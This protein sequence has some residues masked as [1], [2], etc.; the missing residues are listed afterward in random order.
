MTT[1]PPSAS[2]SPIWKRRCWK[3]YAREEYMHRSDSDF[4]VCT[5][6]C[7][8]LPAPDTP[9]DASRRK[10]YEVIDDKWLDE[11]AIRLFPRRPL[12]TLKEGHNVLAVLTVIPLSRST[13]LSSM[14]SEVNELP[15]HI[16][17][18]QI[19]AAAQKRQSPSTGA[20]LAQRLQTQNPRRIDA[21]YDGRPLSLMGPSITIYHTVFANFLKRMQESRHFTSDGLD[22]A[23]NFVTQAAA[24]HGDGSKR[25][26]ELA[27]WTN[28]GVHAHFLR[29]TPISNSVGKFTPDGAVFASRETHDGFRALIS[30]A[31]LETE[32]GEG[33]G[34]PNA[35]A[36]NVYVAYYPS[37][38]AQSVRDRSCCPALLIGLAGPTI[39]VSGAVFA[40]QLVV[41]NLGDPVCVVPRLNTTGRSMLDDAGHRVAQ[42]FY[43]LRECLKEL[44]DYYAALIQ[45]ITVPKRHLRSVGV[46][47]GRPAPTST[48]R[49]G[50]SPPPPMIS[51]HFAQYKD[52]EGKSVTLTYT[53]RL[54]RDYPVKAVFVAEAKTDTETRTVV[55]KFTPAYCKDAHELLARAS[56]PQAPKL[57]FCEFV[58][59]VGMWVVVMDYV[60]GKEVTNVLQDPVHI[61]SLEG[62]I[63][64]LHAD[65]FVFGDLREP[66]VL[67][68]DDK[69][70]LIDFDWCG[71]QG[72]ARYPSDIL[73]EE[74]AW[75]SGVQRGG[76]LEKVHD[77][78]HF[79]ALTGMKLP[80][81]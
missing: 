47:P 53:A 44:D 7:A 18:E 28:K 68:V 76:L 10:A 67:R 1:I 60:E 40:D 61:K 12:A 43:A 8:H 54:A 65:G 27:P 75:H 78:F 38:E 41:Q 5:Y 49:A 72:T 56:P 17:R 58:E 19:A 16:H 22:V 23:Q 4:V 70:V 9:S 36:E 25:H 80:S 48:G 15:G 50:L 69:V 37:R 6:E 33:S 31:E 73:L 34:D 46:M 24:Y 2:T 81:V 63:T 57:R 77:G 39:Q 79:H 59:S 21:V 71:K 14:V 26:T 42:L 64:A 55:V 45:S 30:A 32:L 62:A 51:P 74:G 66:N 20:T 52:D 13:L 35:Q 29:H 3:Q 11:N